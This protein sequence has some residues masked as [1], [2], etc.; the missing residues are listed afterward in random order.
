[1]KGRVFTALLTL[2]VSVRK[3]V[4]HLKCCVLLQKPDH[5]KR[6]VGGRLTAQSSSKAFKVEKQMQDLA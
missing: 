2:L 5:M 1:M 4:T 6:V 3:V